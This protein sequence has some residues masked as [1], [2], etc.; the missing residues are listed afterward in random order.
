MVPAGAEVGVGRGNSA[1]AAAMVS[2]ASISRVGSGL[3]FEA[4]LT[5]K[6]QD[7]SKTRIKLQISSFPNPVIKSFYATRSNHYKL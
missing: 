7:A 3:L 4:L 2:A 5:P 1:V 6:L